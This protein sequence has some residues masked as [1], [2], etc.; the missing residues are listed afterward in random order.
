[1]MSGGGTRHQTR[2][3]RGMPSL[4]FRLSQTDCGGT[5]FEGELVLKGINNTN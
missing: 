1:M 5:G 2:G 3:S 4:V